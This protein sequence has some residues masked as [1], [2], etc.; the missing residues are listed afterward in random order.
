MRDPV[1]NYIY[2]NEELEEKIIDTV[3]IQR[4]RQLYQLPTARF[5]YPG[6]SHSRFLHSLGVM[7]L[8]GKMAT[9][10]LKEV[11]MGKEEKEVLIESSRIVGLLHDCGHGPFS[12]TFDEAIISKEKSLSRKGIES[13]EDISRL[14]LE[15]SKIKDVLQQW[16]LDRVV[17]DLFIAKED[18][19]LLEKSVSR[20]FRKWIFTADVLDFLVRDA[21]FCGVREYGVDVER[22]TRWIKPYKGAIACEKRLL[23]S[24]FNYL[25]TRFYMFD[26]IYFHRTSRA[27]DCLMSEILQKAS[28]ALE[29]VD[30]VE[31][32]RDGDFNDFLALTDYSVI[33]M[34]LHCDPKGDKNLKKAQELAMFVLTREIPIRELDDF[35]PDYGSTEAAILD[36]LERKYTK[37]G[38]LLLEEMRQEVKEEFQ[39]KL[40]KSGYKE[41]TSIYVD[42]TDY[43]YLS[44]YPLAFT[45]E[46]PIYSRRTNK[47]EM[48]PVINEFLKQHAVSPK[49]MRVYASKN[50]EKI[51]GEKI[52]KHK[53]LA[54]TLAD[55]VETT[56]PVF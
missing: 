50:F 31:R 43:R 35:S 23:P 55:L 52:R 42:F 19:S 48:K 32:C 15:K 34:L 16:G 3:F 12:H 54:K 18:L 39:R 14:L 41:R 47:T 29:I 49:K 40:K 51:H 37:R 46:L 30:R 33:D 26:N 28:A 10:L 17:V 6:A 27:I 38:K 25:L 24:V 4:L 36:K 13:H 20:I 1:Y 9:E 44:D 22:I 45:G 8:A 21:Y 7:E 56:E 2:Y 11:D 53:V 5:V